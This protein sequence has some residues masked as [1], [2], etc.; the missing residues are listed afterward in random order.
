MSGSFLFI[1]DIDQLI[2]LLHNVNVSITEQGWVVFVLWTKE[3]L[4]DE[5]MNQLRAAVQRLIV[6]NEQKSMQ[7]NNLRTALDE[8]IKIKAY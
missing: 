2:A 1:F 6:D 8:Q 4:A 3:L 7:I 5:E